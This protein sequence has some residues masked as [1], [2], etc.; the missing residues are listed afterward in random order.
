MLQLFWLSY[1]VACAT[2]ISLPPSVP[3]SLH[4]SLFCRHSLLEEIPFEVLRSKRRAVRVGVAFRSETTQ[5]AKFKINLGNFYPKLYYFV[6]FC[7]SRPARARARLSECSTEMEDSIQFNS[8]SLLRY[9]ILGTDESERER[10][11]ARKWM[12][13]AGRRR[14]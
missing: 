11:R 3:A 12:R 1:S 9:Y 13:L 4:L 7:V 2:A 5:K 8:I 6:V 10:E 14:S